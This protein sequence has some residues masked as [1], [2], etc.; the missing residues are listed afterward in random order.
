MMFANQQ[1][2]HKRK[3]NQELCRCNQA[4]RFEGIIIQ[5]HI[6][7]NY[8]ENDNDVEIELEI[9]RTNIRLMDDKNFLLRIN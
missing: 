2:D 7:S 4:M 9:D 6:N 1:N 3:K 5:L 8:E